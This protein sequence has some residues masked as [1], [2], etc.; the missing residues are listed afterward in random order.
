MR[1][2]STNPFG[3]P[4]AII[5]RHRFDQSNGLGRN[6]GFPASSLGLLAPGP[7]EKVALP[8]EE[9]I[10]LDNEDY[11]LPSLGCPREQ[12]QQ[13]TIRPGTRW[14]LHLTAKDDQL[15]MRASRFQPSVQTWYE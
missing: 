10:R 9:G 8:A 13:Q 5:Q 4:Q 15:L 6:F 14:A 3:A 2:F 11:P 12:D 1:Q 7:A